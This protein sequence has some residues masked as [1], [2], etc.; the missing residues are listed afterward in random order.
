M[1]SEDSDQF[2]SGFLTIHRRGDFDDFGK[3]RTAQVIARGDPVHAAAARLKVIALRG[4]QRMR[5]ERT[6][7]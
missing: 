6:G 5:P 4:S 1:V 3:P 2:G 7:R